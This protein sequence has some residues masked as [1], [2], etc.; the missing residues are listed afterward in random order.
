MPLHS[1]DY[2]ANECHG[3]EYLEDERGPNFS[4]DIFTPTHHQLEIP[5]LLNTPT[6]LSRASNHLTPSNI[7]IKAASRMY[8]PRTSLPNLQGRHLDVKPLPGSTLMIRVKHT[9]WVLW[10]DNG[11]LAWAECDDRDLRYPAPELTWIVVQ[12]EEYKGFLHKGSGMFLGY[13]GDMLMP[14]NNFDGN[15]FFL[16]L[17][18]EYGGYVLHTPAARDTMKQVCVIVTD[19]SLERSIH[20]RSEFEFVRVQRQS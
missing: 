3:N 5:R 18:G 9:G 6:S 11:E 10:I 13:I 2:E 17:K 12:G 1:Q 20:G 16:T 4:C 19:G 15:A 14:V 7:T 8:T